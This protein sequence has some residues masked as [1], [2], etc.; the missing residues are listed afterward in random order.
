MIQW[1]KGMTPNVVM[2]SAEL[3]NYVMCSWVL[4]MSDFV[5]VVQPLVQMD[6]MLDAEWNLPGMILKAETVQK[7]HWMSSVT[8]RYPGWARIVGC[9][10]PEPG[11]HD[12]IYHCVEVD[13]F[14][15]RDGEE[16]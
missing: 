16:V 6:V 4:P 9:K 10:V 5:V 2:H 14:V 13:C 12:V 15:W 3:E 7:N 8:C 11:G 1:V